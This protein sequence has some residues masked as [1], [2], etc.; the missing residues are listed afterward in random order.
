VSEMSVITR[1]CR[2]D[3]CATVLDLW[4][5]AGADPTV[6]D[7]LA[8]LERLVREHADLFLV[9]ER[10]GRLVGTAIAGWDG[11]RGHLYRVAV[12][13]AC[14][15]QGIGR[16]LVREALRRLDARG[17]HRIWC[18]V[19]REEPEAVAF[20]DGLAAEGLVQDT[21]MVRYTRTRTLM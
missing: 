16:A 18:L 12:L 6:T 5:A 13:P 1:P 21:R 14:R 9:A 11:W 2:L 8:D 4:T 15:R 19:I 7:T 10:D 3:E 17:A 20:W